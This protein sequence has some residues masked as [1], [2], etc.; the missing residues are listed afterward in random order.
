[1]RIEFR[2]ITS[3][4]TPFSLETEAYKCEGSFRKLA[5]KLVEIDMHL[6]ATSELVCDRCGETFPHHIDEN[7]KL[8]ITDGYFEGED[9]DVIE[10]FDHFVD[11]DTIVSGEIE[12]IRNDY[13]ICDKC[14]ENQGE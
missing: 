7:M 2:K 8:R 5:H 4:V 9:L 14:K 11:F 3:N 1:M 13:H 6:D 10:V 12:T